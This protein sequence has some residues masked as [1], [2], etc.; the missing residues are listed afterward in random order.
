[1]ITTITTTHHHHHQRYRYLPCLLSASAWDDFLPP[2]KNDNETG[3]APGP[4]GTWWFL[5]DLMAM[6][7]CRGTCSW[8]TC[9]CCTAS[10]ED[11]ILALRGV[12]EALGLCPFSNIQ[13]RQSSSCYGNSMPPL[14]PIREA[15]AD[16]KRAFA[17]VAP[18]G[19][20][21]GVCVDE[22]GQSIFYIPDL[23]S[24]LEECVPIR[25]S[26][27]RNRKIAVPSVSNLLVL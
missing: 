18:V 5:P 22:C 7:S 26:S 20:D 16:E 17:E 3:T 15:T 19:V 24:H 25:S 1:M 14:C 10:G 9:C 21:R 23:Q 8:G 11:A 12:L 27:F 6:I 13:R 2:A 4:R